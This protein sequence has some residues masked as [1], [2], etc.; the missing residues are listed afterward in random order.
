MRRAVWVIAGLALMAVLLSPLPASSAPGSSACTISYRYA[1]APYPATAYHV[2]YTTFGQQLKLAGQ[3]RFTINSCGSITLSYWYVLGTMITDYGL[4]CV[5][6]DR[7]KKAN[8][9][10]GYL[11]LRTA[12][13]KVFKSQASWADAEPIDKPLGVTDAHFDVVAGDY[14]IKAKF[15]F[16]TRQ[17]VAGGTFTGSF[18]RTC[19]AATSW[20]RSTCTNGNG[21]GSW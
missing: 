11:Y 14:P 18:T 13:G 4:V 3:V 1:R 17:Y 2:S 19:T 5:C 9:V 21:F 8:S 16:V 10:R 15:S 6:D 7:G 12:Q 20:S